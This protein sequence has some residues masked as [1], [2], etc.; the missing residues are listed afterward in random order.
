MDE[1]LHEV[2]RSPPNEAM[3]TCY[4]GWGRY[5]LETG[6]TVIQIGIC[7]P[8]ELWSRHQK[9]PTIE[10]DV[11]FHVGEPL[12]PKDFEHHDD[13]AHAKTTEIVKQLSILSGRNSGGVHEKP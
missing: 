9:V 11:S 8:Y 13:A 4:R 2:R 7:G 1:F 6:I 10:K 12:L 5:V 3:L